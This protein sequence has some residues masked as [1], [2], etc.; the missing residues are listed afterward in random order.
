VANNKGL[1]K[2][3]L[4]LWF[5]S[6]HQYISLSSQFSRHVKWPIKAMS[7]SIGNVIHSTNIKT[8]AR[9]FLSSGV[10]LGEHV[11]RNKPESLPVSGD[12]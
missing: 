8:T 12:W 6:A 11:E 10:S 3:A 9:T 5:F 1:I 7:L 2:L 4:L